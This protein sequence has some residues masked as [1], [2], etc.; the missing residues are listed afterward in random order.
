MTITR[1]QEFLAWAV[2]TFGPVALNRDERAARFI[3][4][5]LELAHAESIQKATVLSIVERVYARPAGEL[6]KEIGQAAATL[7]CLAEN[8][9]ISAAD[10]CE[11]ELKRVKSIPKEQWA[12]RHSAKVALGIADLSPSAR[13]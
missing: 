5:A 7:E 11:R 12:K 6:R 8:V 1:P 3:E 4:E 10:E 13:P 9:G 2:D